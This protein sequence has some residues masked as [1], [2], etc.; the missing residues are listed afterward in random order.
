MWIKLFIKSL[1]CK[2]SDIKNQLVRVF[3]WEKKVKDGQSYIQCAPTHVDKAFSYHNWSLKMKTLLSSCGKWLCRTKKTPRISQINRWICWEQ[4][5]WRT[6]HPCTF[7]T[8]LW[9]SMTLRRLQMQNL[10]KKCETFWRRHIRGWSNEIGLASN[11]QGRVGVHEDERDW[12][13]D[14]V[15]YSS[16]NNDKPLE[17]TERCCPLVVLLKRFLGRWLK[18]S[19]MQCVWL[20]SPRT[21]QHSWL[22]ILSHL[23]RCTS[24]ERRKSGSHLRNYSK[25]SERIR[26]LK[27]EDETYLV[28]EAVMVVEVE[29]KKKRNNNLVNKIGSKE[30]E[31]HEEEF[32]RTT[33]MLSALSVTS[34]W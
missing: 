34:M 11:T 30:N 16:W 15:H 33:Q 22:K 5:I 10:Q 29:D 28:Y 20:R 25:W 9:T 31:V 18:T 21:C 23:L 24:N 7:C 12:G 1:F 13:S 8:K 4:H 14:R 32:S 26:T 19:R 6:M 27:E 2:Q 17:E 3:E